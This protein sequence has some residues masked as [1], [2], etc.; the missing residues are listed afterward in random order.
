[1]D[2]R[3]TRRK[4]RPR[5]YRLEVD[6]AYAAIADAEVARY[7]VALAE[8]RERAWDQIVD[9][10]PEAINFVAPGTT[11]SIG[12]VAAHLAHGEADWIT[13]VTGTPPPAAVRDHPD[14]ARFTPYGSVP[15]EFGP[16]DSLVELG[17]LVE[18]EITLPALAGAV[19]AGGLDRPVPD[20]PLETLGEVLAHLLW[21][22][23][24][25]SGH[26]GLV[27]LQWGGEYDWTFA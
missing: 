14:Y 12:W 21:H 2:E 10:P 11:L 19:G 16:A 13:R 8:L 7:A 23:S 5:R 9:L 25:H 18:R 15:T 17:R 4:G 26:L 3:R 20:Q 24:F 22:W 6:G 1:M 27:R